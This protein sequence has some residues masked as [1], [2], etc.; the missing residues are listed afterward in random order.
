[1]QSITERIDNITGI[2]PEHLGTNIPAPKSVK[3]ELTGRCNFQ[4]NFCASK[5]RL[6]TKSDMDFAFYMRIVKEMRQAGVEELGLFYL[7][8]SF[9]SS[10]LIRAIGYAKNICRYPYTFLTTNGSIAFGARVK[11]CFI[12]GLDSLKFSLNYATPEQLTEIA[13][14]KAAIFHRIIDNIRAA[15][16]ARDEIAEET[17]HHCGLYA[18]YIQ[19]NDEQQKRME[20]V[21][22]EVRPYV[23]Q[24]YALPLYN[25]AALVPNAKAVQGNLGRYDNMRQP[26]PCWS[27]FTEGHI[28]W[29]GKLSACCFDHDGRF[30]MGDL[31]TTPFMEAW[32]S[33]LFQQLRQKHIERDVTSTVCEKCV[34][35][36]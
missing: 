3:I 4:C 34:A 28:T 19:Y 1:M 18:S 17:G 2:D 15:K 30:E 7:G 12:A 25:Q 26:L 35:W 29:D 5:Q 13:G 21:I 14:V 8:E 27:I 22:E 33:V 23:D 20:P 10:D 31:N 16:L 6:R 24:I 11:E 32:N 9:L 36:S